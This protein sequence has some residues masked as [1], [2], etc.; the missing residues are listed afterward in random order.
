LVRD[1]VL[2]EVIRRKPGDLSSKDHL[3][4]ITQ[5]ARARELLMDPV[6]HTYLSR[7][8]SF[9]PNIVLD[10][11]SN[12]L[13]LL[14]HCLVSIRESAL[15][16]GDKIQS[17]VPSILDRIEINSKLSRVNL[18]QLISSISKFSELVSPHPRFEDLVQ[19]IV[20]QIIE[21]EEFKSFNLICLINLNIPGNL[22]KLFDHYNS[23][24]LDDSN[25]VSDLEMLS[26][27]RALGRVRQLDKRV[28]EIRLIPKIKNLN[29]NSDQEKGI[30]NSLISVGIKWDD[31]IS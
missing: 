11:R 25:Q 31:I 8:L 16:A 27:I 14:L 3:F 13:C 12:D 22:Q 5:I 20:N 7:A 18:S 17:L 2:K 29:L 10:L 15:E 9:I 24:L 26:I 30:K 28:V 19:S 1:L 6:V 21:L 23:Y 4:L